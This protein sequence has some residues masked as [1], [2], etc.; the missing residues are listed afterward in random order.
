MPVV[1]VSLIQGYS[2]A[3]KQQLC[4]RLTEAVSASIAADPDA[5]TIFL[6]E[7][8]ADGY[9]RGGRSRQPGSA[10]AVPE[11]SLQTAPESLVRDFLAAMEARELERAS[12]LL[13]D[14]FVM[15][16]PGSPPMTRLTEL[17]EW[18]RGRYRHV[19]KRIHALDCCDKGDHTVVVC[20]GELHGEWPDGTPF[21]GVR[22]IDRF[23]LRD[24]KLARQEVWNDLALAS[25]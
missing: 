14:D 10:R 2:S 23:E 11:E 20:H 16:F 3:L 7:V 9:M 18:A 22:F 5:I 24:G 8:A 15:R 4:E 12:S 13:A 17:V 6:H 1:Q 19:G 25:P 21:D